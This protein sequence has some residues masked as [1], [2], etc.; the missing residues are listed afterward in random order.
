MK[1]LNQK[2]YPNYRVQTVTSQTSRSDE[3]DVFKKAGAKNVITLANPRGG[4]AIDIQTTKEADDAGG[5]L[6]VVWG[7]LAN[8]TVLRQVLA[9]TARA[10]HPGE[11]KW[12]VYGEGGKL[13]LSQ[14]QTVIRFP[15]L[16][17]DL[18]KE[19]NGSD[20]SYESSLIE[21]IHLKNDLDAQKERLLAFAYDLYAHEV[22]S[23]VTRLVHEE[24][25][26]KKL[27]QLPRSN[28]YLPNITK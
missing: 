9:R 18:L 11:V 14:S 23:E 16:Q 22:R 7:A 5:L 17:E 25:K 27:S 15:Q 21:E 13:G 3:R 24:F 10:G 8:K 20:L 1:S 12:L 2:N 4:R 6:L 26:S 28:C 19:A